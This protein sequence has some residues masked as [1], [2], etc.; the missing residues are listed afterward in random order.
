MPNKYRDK[1]SRDLQKFKSFRK[2]IALD[3]SHKITLGQVK[4][5]TAKKGGL[6]DYNSQYNK[7]DLPVHLLS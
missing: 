7:F 5:G 6:Q 1:P 2:N 3:I 4:F